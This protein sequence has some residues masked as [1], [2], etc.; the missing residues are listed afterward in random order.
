MARRLLEKDAA[1]IKVLDVSSLVGYTDCIIVC[2]GRNDRQNRA[3]ADHV[4][5]S[6]AAAG[7]KPYSVDGYREGTWIL[8]DY[9]DVMAHIFLPEIREFYN[10]D[11]LWADAPELTGWKDA[12][13]GAGAR[14]RTDAGTVKTALRKAPKKR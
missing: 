6:M 4:I 3:V 5:E 13:T 2:E 14:E 9:S 11:G 8:L 1:R 12:G 7:R 10:L